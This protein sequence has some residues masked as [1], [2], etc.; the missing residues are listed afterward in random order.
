MAPDEIASTIRAILAS[1][2]SMH[3]VKMF[4]G[5]GF[6]LRGN[7]LV[8][9]SK[10]GLLVRVGE[11]GQAEALSKPGTRAMEMRGRV[12]QG[13]V[14]VAPEALTEASIPSWLALARSFVETLPTKS[15]AA[16]KKGK[17]T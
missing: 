17:K 1:V 16:T 6:M 9:V 7:M 13:Y 4:G 2:P 3:E 12:M 8:A 14:F 5:I 15:N 10:R 11:N